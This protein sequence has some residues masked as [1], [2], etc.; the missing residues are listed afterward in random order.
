MVLEMLNILEHFD[1]AAM[2]HNSVDY[3]RTV[4]EAMKRATSDKDLYVGDPEF[5]DVPLDRLISKAHA[6]SHSDEIRSGQRASVERMS[7]ES[8]DTTHVC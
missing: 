2:G 3:L 6:R 1:L 7:Y 8:K 5:V 4:T